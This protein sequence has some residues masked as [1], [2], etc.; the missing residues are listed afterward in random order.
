MRLS[1]WVCLEGV[2]GCFGGMWVCWVGVLL[3]WG[4]CWGMGYVFLVMFT[5]GTFYVEGWSLFSVLRIHSACGGV[6]VL[7]LVLGTIFGGG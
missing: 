7:F 1:M 2:Y 5:L 6:L 4:I 3:F